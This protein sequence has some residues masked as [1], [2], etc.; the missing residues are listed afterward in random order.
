MSLYKYIYTM[1]SA[2]SATWAKSSRSIS[3]LKACFLEWETLHHLLMPRL[4]V[5]QL[6]CQNI[7]LFWHTV[8]SDSGFGL[9]MALRSA[10][11]LC[12]CLHWQLA[13]S[14]LAWFITS[15]AAHKHS[16]AVP[17]QNWHISFCE[18]SHNVVGTG[19]TITIAHLKPIALVATTPRACCCRVS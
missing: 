6:S 4:E 1:N 19:A 16:L 2:A 9:E 18:E 5:P 7:A 10:S 3:T 8:C 17:A 12:N 13:C 15:Q 14:V 11:L